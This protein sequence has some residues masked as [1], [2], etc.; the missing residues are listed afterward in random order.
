MIFLSPSVSVG[1]SQGQL[2]MPAHVFQSGMSA[3]NI[4]QVVLPTALCPNMQGHELF[5]L[6]EPPERGNYITALFP[7]HV[8]R[9]R[10][11]HFKQGH[12]AG[13]PLTHHQSV[14]EACGSVVTVLPSRT[15]SR[16]AFSNMV[17]FEEQDARSAVECSM[18]FGVFSSLVVRL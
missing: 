4:S 11:S 17:P 9:V 1:P 5:F 14:T 18:I 15:F 3:I 10:T 8:L 16:P 12:P 7:E 2:R 6:N 13:V